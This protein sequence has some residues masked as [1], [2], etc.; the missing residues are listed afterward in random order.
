MTM[1]TQCTRR[2]LLIGGAAVIGAG[3]AGRSFGF[4][5]TAP[6]GKVAIG[7]CKEYGAEMV[8]A[9][10]RMFDQLGGLEGL[11]KGKTV[12][13]KINMVGEIYY[14]L[15]HLPP[16]DTYWTNP[17]LIGA[18]VHLM[19]RAGARR[20]RILEGCWAS[21]EPLEEYWLRANWEPREV[22]SAAPR[23]EFENINNLGRGKKYSRFK[24][25]HG[26]YIF[27][28]YELNHSFEDLDVFVSLTKMKEHATAGVT[29]SEKNC[30]GST[31]TSIYGEGA[32]V[33]EPN[34]NPLGGRGMMHSGNRQPS[35][36]ALPEIDPKSS[37]DPGFRMPRIIADIVAARPV[38]LAIIDAVKTMT[39]GEGPWIN[40]LKQVK[41]GVIL[42]G[43]NCVSTDA[44]A[45]SVMGYDP[46]AERGT[47]PFG[48]SRIPRGCD[49]TLKLAEELGV[50]SRDLKRI[51]VAGVPVKDV[52]FRYEANRPGGT[53]G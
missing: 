28:A 41:P 23:V 25:P 38:H 4:A 50:G 1:S 42:A 51:E 45:L 22:L 18:V 12:G 34:E 21:P 31:P 10:S 20:V 17:H 9:L 53:G 43:T 19:G 47:A 14:R 30:F 52:V 15:G 35:K 8:P 36:A 49:N 6:A 11:V 2:Q 26:G 44:V 32:G 3:Y 27:P 40:N 13:I 16:E 7:R 33:D 48:G 46:M 5:E 37:R 24:V 39:G 29:L